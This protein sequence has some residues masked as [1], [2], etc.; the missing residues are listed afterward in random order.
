MTPEQVTAEKTIGEGNPRKI[1]ILM[2]HRIVD[3][4][5][6]NSKH[7]TC[8]HVREFRRQLESLERWG[9]TAITFDDYRLYLQGELNLPRKP[10]VLTFDDAYLDTYENAFPLLQEYGMRAVIF[11]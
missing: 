4:K 6:A 9:F 3:D 1:K 7:W 5:E 10:V 8:I 2:Y 11:P